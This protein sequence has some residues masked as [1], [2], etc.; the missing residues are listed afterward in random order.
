MSAVTV[1][2][3][4]RKPLTQPSKQG[5]RAELGEMEM[6]AVDHKDEALGSKEH[7]DARHLMWQ[8]PQPT[9]LAV[10]QGRAQP[11]TTKAGTS[12]PQPQPPVS[13]TPLELQGGVG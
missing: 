13:A 4:E 8:F 10:A 12:V 9:A 7:L 1:G 6:W 5:R 3:K 2:G 11:T